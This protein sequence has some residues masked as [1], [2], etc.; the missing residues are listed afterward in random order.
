MNV[1]EFIFPFAAL[2][3]QEPLQQALLLSAIDPA[4]GGVLVSGPRGTAKSTAARALAELLP[5]GQFVTLPLGASGE[6][7][8]GSLDIGV[9]FADG[10]VGVSLGAFQISTASRL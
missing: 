8:I 2:V 5:G 10:G 9:G 3:A 1:S 4:L 7:L 6:Q